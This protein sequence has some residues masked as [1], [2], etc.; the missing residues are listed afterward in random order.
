[1]TRHV[2]SSSDAEEQENWLAYV[3][4]T[5]DEDQLKR[6]VEIWTRQD[7]AQPS[8]FDLMLADDP[9]ANTLDIH[10]TARVIPRLA[11]LAQ[12]M[13]DEAWWTTTPTPGGP[14]GEVLAYNT[15]DE[16]LGYFRAN[17]V[18]GELEAA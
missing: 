7:E 8:L 2:V 6:F 17:E 18:V 5:L 16:A 14:R 3:H 12:E 1:V 4:R 9:V 13:H 15:F 11:S 10:P